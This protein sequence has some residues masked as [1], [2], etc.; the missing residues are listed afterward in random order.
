MIWCVKLE[1]YT[2]EISD[3]SGFDFFLWNALLKKRVNLQGLCTQ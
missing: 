2:L 1:F 3:L